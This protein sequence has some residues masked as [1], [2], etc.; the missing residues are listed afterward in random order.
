MG[1]N[2]QRWPQTRTVP[3]QEPCLIRK[4]VLMLGVGGGYLSRLG[5]AGVGGSDCKI[6]MTSNFLVQRHVAIANVKKPTRSPAA[7]SLANAGPVSS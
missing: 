4:A 5:T 1:G 3:V 7:R 6:E 2:V